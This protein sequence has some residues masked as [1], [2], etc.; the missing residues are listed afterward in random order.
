M[1]KSTCM[2]I[3]FHSFNGTD[4][5]QI[6][7][8]DNPYPYDPSFPTALVFALLFSIAGC[9]HLYLYFRHRAW[10]LY[11]ILLGIASKIQPGLYPAVI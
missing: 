5:I 1:A 4:T 2:S 7:S 10:F 11:F 8:D 6:A 3:S 9:Y